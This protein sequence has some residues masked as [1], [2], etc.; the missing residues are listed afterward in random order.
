MSGGCT[1]VFDCWLT[2]KSI[3]LLDMRTR[4]ERQE[5]LLIVPTCDLTILA[6]TPLDHVR[7]T[8][9]GPCSS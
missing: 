9:R 6:T 4:L 1:L 8:I 2:A 5:L 7:M 3:S